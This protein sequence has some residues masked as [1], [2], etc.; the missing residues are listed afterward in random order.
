MTIAETKVISFLE[1][2]KPV[3]L[4]SLFVP[5]DHAPK[6]KQPT[7]RGVSRSADILFFFLSHIL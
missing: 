4:D 3:N 1:L 6:P 7:T 2:K 5:T